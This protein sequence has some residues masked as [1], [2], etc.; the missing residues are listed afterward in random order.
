MKLNDESVLRDLRYRLTAII[1][2]EE[3]TRLETERRLKRL[4]ANAERLTKRIA[5]LEA[6]D[7]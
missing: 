7:D 6:S 4:A 5:R 2:E 3:S 1:R